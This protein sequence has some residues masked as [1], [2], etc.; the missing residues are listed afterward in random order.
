MESCGVIRTYHRSE[1]VIDRKLEAFYSYHILVPGIHATTGII[2]VLTLLEPRSRC[3]DK[4]PRIKLIC[5]QSGT[6]VLGVKQL[7]YGVPGI[8]VLYL[9]PGRLVGYGRKSCT[10]VLRGTILNRTSYRQKSILRI[11]CYFYSKYSVLF[12]MTPRNSFG[13]LILVPLTLWC[14]SSSSPVF[15]LYFLYLRDTMEGSHTKSFDGVT[16]LFKFRGLVSQ[17]LGGST[18]GPYYQRRGE[19][20]Q[21]KVSGK[22]TDLE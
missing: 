11:F 2:V 3:G 9:V 13:A 16:S 20:E 14:M 18:V 1:H 4:L 5:P 21:S 8:S 17:C 7:L 12:T 6:A 19:G 10:Q 22:S 15:L